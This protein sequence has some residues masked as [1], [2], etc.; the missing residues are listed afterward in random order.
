M[1]LVPVS[2]LFRRYAA[3]IEFVCV[4]VKKPTTLAT[5]ALRASE[6]GVTTFRSSKI[7]TILIDG[8]PLSAIM[9]KALAGNYPYPQ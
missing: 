6:A 5:S 2:N 4:A 8:T 1:R 3:G 9:D 7:H